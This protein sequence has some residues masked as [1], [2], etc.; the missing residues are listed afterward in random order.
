MRTVLD[1]RANGSTHTSPLRGGQSRGDAA[2]ARHA[3]EVAS[4]IEGWL[5]DAQGRALME[6]AAATKGRGVIVEIGSWKGRS[7]TWLAAGARLAGQRVFAVD[8]HRGSREAPDACT[9]GE[10]LDNL[11]RAGVADHV[12]PL[13]MTS[14][15]AADHVRD[16]VELL[17]ID[18][19]HS[20]DGARQDADLWLPRLV[21]GGVVMFHD[22]ATA[23]YGGPRDVFRRRVCRAVG[24]DSIRRVG[25]MGVAR[26]TARRGLRAAA[27]GF[28]FAWLLYLYDL[29]QIFRRV[30]KPIRGFFA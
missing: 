20:Y 7:S 8:P 14:A 18:G 19:D 9:L 29:Q 26:R 4:T 3:A 6:A 16:P 2:A 25:S 15:A 28:T 23:G 17:F 21:E 11:R 10:F 12:E 22:V 1:P 30:T 13:V 5:S 27:W 24:F